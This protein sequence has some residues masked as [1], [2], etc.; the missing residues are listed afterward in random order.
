M[1]ETSPPPP[2]PPDE[3][4]QGALDL[5]ALALATAPTPQE[6]RAAWDRLVQLKAREREI[7]RGAA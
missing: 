6:R 7:A 5:A 1:S 3:H 4:L 2:L